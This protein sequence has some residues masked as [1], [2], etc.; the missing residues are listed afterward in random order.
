MDLIV[1]GEETDL[2]GHP[3]DM[4]AYSSLSLLVP[5]QQGQGSEFL[6]VESCWRRGQPWCSQPGAFLKCYLPG[7]PA[8]PLL[9]VWP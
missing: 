5:L 1:P 3:V 8:V 7:D 4:H 2:Q 9:G 6:Q